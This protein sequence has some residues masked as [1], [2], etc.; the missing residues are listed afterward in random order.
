MGIQNI[1]QGVDLM[2]GSLSYTGENLSN[3]AFT[4][5]TPSFAYDKGT[6]TLLLNQSPI[7]S[8]GAPHI[9]FLN[10]VYIKLLI[11]HFY[12]GGNAEIL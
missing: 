11:F 1:R 3:L 6:V 12:A 8:L 4:S 5:F 7:N 10:V 9:N 2:Y